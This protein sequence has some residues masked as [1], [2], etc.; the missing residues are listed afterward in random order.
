MQTTT[1]KEKNIFLSF[2][3]ILFFLFTGYFGSAQVGIGTTNPLSTFEVNGTFGQKVNTIT[4]T[5]TLDDTFGSLI[6]CDN[7]AT[8]ITVTLPVVSSCTGRLYIIKRNITSTTNVTIAGTIDGVTNLVLAKTG[9]AVTLFSNGLEWKSASTNNASATSGWNLKGNSDTD[10]AANFIGTTDAND[11]VFKTNNV[12]KLRVLS[13]GNIGIGVSAPTAAIQIKAGTAAAGTAPLKLTDGPLTAAAEPG[14]IEYK[15]HTFYASTSLVRRSIMLAQDVVVQS[16][17]V[18]GTDAETTIYTTTLE[19]GYLTP[20]KM[21]N[22]K[23][24]GSY[25]TA[26]SASSFVVKVK[27]A[28]VN[29]LTSASLPAATAENDRPIDLDIRSIIRSIGTAGTL[30][31][32]GKIQQDNLAAN[33]DISASTEINTTIA[34]DITITIQWAVANAENRFSLEGGATQC[35][36]ANY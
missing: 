6:I 13:G 35:V 8:A 26:S 28:G 32:Y 19:A 14:A 31:S 7:G 10:P 29:I 23:L 36:D 30:I 5:T 4:E 24:F 2:L 9:E 17:P 33:I 16:V 18:T 21:I 11:L 22:I 27:L 15:G 1:L 3:S 20:G 12:E 34:N 25:R